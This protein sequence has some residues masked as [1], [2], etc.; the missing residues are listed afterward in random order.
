M[1]KVLTLSAATLAPILLAL[2]SDPRIIEAGV[3]AGTYPIPWPPDLFGTFGFF[4]VPIFAIGALQLFTRQARRSPQALLV[5]VWLLVS[6]IVVF[7]AFP[8]PGLREWAYRSL[9]LI[10]IPVFLSNGTVVLFRAVWGLGSRMGGISM[11]RM[12]RVFGTICLAVLVF[13]GAFLSAL[14]VQAYAGIHMRSFIS[15]DSRLALQQLSDSGLVRPDPI[16]VVYMDD[17]WTGGF[18]QLWDNWIGIYFGN[19]LVY[20]GRLFYFF[21]G[22]E[23]PFNSSASRSISDLYFSQLSSRNLLGTKVITSHDIVILTPFYSALSSQ[24]QKILSPVGPEGYLVSRNATQQALLSVPL[25]LSGFYDKLAVVGHWY[26]IAKPWATNNLVLEL[27]LPNAS[28]H[29]S[30]NYAAYQFSTVSRAEYNITLGT[31]DYETRYEP[32]SFCVNELCHT[33]RYSGSLL[34]MTLSISTILP[35]GPNQ[36]RVNATGNGPLIINLDFFTIS[37]T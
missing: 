12:L 8:F 7:A 25:T 1:R 34:P 31:F 32:W 21:Q 20:P 9:I 28:S 35:S 27:Y 2:A 36:I 13:S 3:S 5:T 24:E 15:D 30:T 4:L 29:V 37:E 16:F 6:L 22:M 23:T 11:F 33:I 26:G 14:Q 19:H 18:A 10:P 17:Y